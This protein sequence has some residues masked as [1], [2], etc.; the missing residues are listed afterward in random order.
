M[1]GPASYPLLRLPWSGR[2]PPPGLLTAR[3]VRGHTPSLCG[4]SSA[5]A[6]QAGW[7]LPPA[8]LGLSASAASSLSS[9]RALLSC[10]C[11]NTVPPL[12]RSQFGLSA[13]GAF[14]D[15]SLPTP[16]ATPPD[17]EPPGQG[18]D[19]KP[20]PPFLLPAARAP[21]THLVT[22]M[23]GSGRVGET[24]ARRSN[25]ETPRGVWRPLPSRGPKPSP[26]TQKGRLGAR[27]GAK[28]GSKLACCGDRGGGPTPGGTSAGFGGA[29]GGAWPGPAGYL[30]G[31]GCSWAGP[32][33][34]GA[35]P[36]ARQPM[37]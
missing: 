33:R 8:P 23:S 32:G 22:K 35:G 12:S 14:R 11:R 20:Q 30:P 6:A 26:W 29:A 18:S 21:R 25:P 5:P 15:P 27:G 3:S 19:H 34:Q 17:R 36:G 1:L 37:G 16:S 28:R 9:A 2:H 10:L 31:G 7:P 24:A 13:P 4:P